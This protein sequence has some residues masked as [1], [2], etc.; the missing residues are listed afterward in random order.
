MHIMFVKFFHAPR[1]VTW[2]C[3]ANFC[4]HGPHNSA[5][6]SA[7]GHSF[8]KVKPIVVYGEVPKEGVNHWSHAQLTRFWFV[9]ELTVTSTGNQICYFRVGILLLFSL[10]GGRVNISFLSNKTKEEDVIVFNTVEITS[11]L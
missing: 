4:A 6:R 9:L 3:Q 5:A 8:K 1:G 10:R 7:S 2:T 11:S